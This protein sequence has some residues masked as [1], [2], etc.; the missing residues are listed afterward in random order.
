MENMTEIDQLKESNYRPETIVIINCIFNAPL[1]LISIIGNSLVLAAILRTPSL[2]SPSILFLCSLAVSDLFVG[3]IVQPLYIAYELTKF[4][5]LYEL[6]IA[7][8]VNGVGVSLGT[9]TVISLDRFLALHYHMRYPDMVTIHR[10]KYTIITLW[11]FTFL[12]SFLAFWKITAYY[13]LAA[14]SIP[15]YLLLSTVCYVRIYFIVRRHQLQILAQ[16]NAVGS[17]NDESNI[18]R[19]VKS[20]KNTFIYYIVMILC[21]TPLFISMTIL[22]FFYDRWT[23]A[24]NL[25]D[26]AVFL[27]SSINPFLYCWRL[28]ELRTAVIK[29]AR[30]ML[31]KNTE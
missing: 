11:L 31:C 18:Q 5:S 19:S 7:M 15:I 24:W 22:F 4:S 30:E 23:V 16:Q 26:T 29:T 9:I 25:S 20:A 10:A 13:F 12:V 8:S 2:N 14:V 21:Y 6:M 3:F 1:M 28:R 17:L 27:N